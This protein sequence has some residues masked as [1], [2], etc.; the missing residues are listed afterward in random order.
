MY[1]FASLSALEP[2]DV[3]GERLPR[4]GQSGYAQL[5]YEESLSAETCALGDSDKHRSEAVVEGSDTGAFSG[6][7]NA[8]AKAKD[9]KGML[10]RGDGDVDGDVDGDDDGDVDGDDDGDEESD[11]SPL[12][13]LSGEAI[14]SRSSTLFRSEARSTVL[15]QPLSNIFRFG[16]RRSQLAKIM[17]TQKGQ[18]R[19]IITIQRGL[20]RFI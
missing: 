6:I 20:R 2:E 16:D 4:F 15:K 5:V 11:G 13:V 7:A 18:M 12:V 17:N 9:G 8:P 19:V 3:T 14:A 10:D 1:E